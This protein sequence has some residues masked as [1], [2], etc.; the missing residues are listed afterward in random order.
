[1]QLQTLFICISQCKCNIICSF[2]G[3]KDKVKKN[4]KPN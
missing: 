3:N 1:L 4:E 2:A